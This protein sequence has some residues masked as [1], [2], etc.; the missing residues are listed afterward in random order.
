MCEPMHEP[1]NEQPVNDV[2]P[3]GPVAAIDCGTNTIK[4]LIGSLPEVAVR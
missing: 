4:L 2:V 1:V 3:S